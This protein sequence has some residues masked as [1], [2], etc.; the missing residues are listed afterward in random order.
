MNEKTS[1]ALALT[2][3]IYFGWKCIKYALI[4]FWPAAL[5]TVT[6]KL[7]GGTPEKWQDSTVTTLLVVSL[8]ITVPL[9]FWAKKHRVD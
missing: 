1:S 3:L 9:Y 2:G 6:A 7:F 8:F 5:V 4:F